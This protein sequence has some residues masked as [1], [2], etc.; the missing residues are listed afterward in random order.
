MRNVRGFICGSVWLLILHT[1]PPYLIYTHTHIHKPTF[2]YIHIYLKNVCS[3]FAVLF[4]TIFIPWWAVNVTEWGLRAL[5]FVQQVYQVTLRWQ[6]TSLKALYTWWWNPW[7]SGGLL[8][9]AFDTVV[10]LA[11]GNEQFKVNSVVLVR[12]AMNYFP[13]LMSLLMESSLHFCLCLVIKYIHSLSHTSILDTNKIQGYY[14]K[15]FIGFYIYTVCGMT[16]VNA[17]SG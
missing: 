15:F 9:R 7:L 13:A 10:V 12:L 8:L 2:T 11:T 6:V 17:L 3:H 14:Y 5:S 1:R 4:P 16:T